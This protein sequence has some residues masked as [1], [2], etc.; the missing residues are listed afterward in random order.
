M[1]TAG[2]RIQEVADQVVD[3]AWCVSTV[4]AQAMKLADALKDMRANMIFSE[5]ADQFQEN[6]DAE[7]EF[8]VMCNA[9]E[10]AC[11]AMRKCAN[12]VRKGN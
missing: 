8:Y 10:T 4:A 3:N 7:T 11:L 12:A 9:L 5:I 6:S 1:E 2:K